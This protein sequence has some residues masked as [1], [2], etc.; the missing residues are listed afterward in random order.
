MLTPIEVTTCSVGSFYVNFLI[1]RK[2]G[3]YLYL[4]G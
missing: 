2:F 1:I 3:A 4:L